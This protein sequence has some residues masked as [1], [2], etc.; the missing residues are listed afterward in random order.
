MRAE[1]ALSQNNRLEA[2]CDNQ[3]DGYVYVFQLYKGEQLVSRL[4]ATEENHGIFWLTESGKYHVKVVA[5]REESRLTAYSAPVEY[6]GIKITLK[7]EKHRETPLQSAKY[8]LTEVIQNWSRMFRI[9]IYDHRV[10]DKDSYLGKLWTVLN[11][12]IQ[13]LT[14]WLVFGVG[15]RGGQPI[16]GYPYL[17]WMLCGLLPW[18]F[19]S[20]GIVGGSASVYSKA[21]TVLRM[22]YPLATIPLGNILV[23][24]FDHLVI[25]ALLIIVEI[26]YGFAPTWC[27]LNIIYYWMFSIV[28]LYA[29]GMFTSTLTMIARDFQKLITSLIR[30]LFY[31]TP[32]LWSLDS[33]PAFARNIL[34]M[35]PAAYIVNGYR[36]SFLYGVN[37]WENAGDMVF[38]WGLT[39][40]IFLLGSWMHRKYRD[41]FIDFL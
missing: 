10:R 8:I 26:C 11:P 1:I 36:D 41:N 22:Q 31:M 6:E 12:L 7:E 25:M 5:T 37:F 14:F 24:F 34:E 20:A 33:M 21:G 38:F 17:L 4:F 35:N 15:F 32:I 13:V 23:S 30:L 2:S 39:L 9:A 16:N 28:F 29:L 18:F 27:W 40:C 3:G 19:V